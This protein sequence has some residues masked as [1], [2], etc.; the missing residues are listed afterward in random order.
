MQPYYVL[1]RQGG[2]NLRGIIPNGPWTSAYV[3]VMTFEGYMYFLPW[4]HDL[5]S[6]PESIIKL[7]GEGKIPCI[8]Q[9]TQRGQSLE[10]EQRHIYFL[11]SQTKFPLLENIN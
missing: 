6:S 5:Y 10:Q 8:P 4:T 2:M 9:V 11:E 1:L 3:G 7:T